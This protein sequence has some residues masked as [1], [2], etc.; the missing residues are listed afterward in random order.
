VVAGG[1]SAQERLGKAL[2]SARLSAGLSQGELAGRIGS[3][4]AMVSRWEAGRVPLTLGTL[5]AVA[6]GMGVDATLVLRDR[7][8]RS[9]TIFI[10]SGPELEFRQAAADWRLARRHHAHDAQPACSAD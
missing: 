10:G 6:G 1:V 2:R 9:T 8:G 5:A 3:S 4:Q 7:Q